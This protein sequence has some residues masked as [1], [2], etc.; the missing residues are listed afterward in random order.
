MSDWR[1]IVRDRI[2]PVHAPHADKRRALADAIRAFVRPGMCLNPVSLQARPVAALH[3][4]IRQ[5]HGMHPRFTFVSSSLSGNY[6]QLVGAGLL[7]RAIVSFAC[8]RSVMSRAAA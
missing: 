3:E 5:F 2:G 8:L 1:K 4:L 7:E 6:L